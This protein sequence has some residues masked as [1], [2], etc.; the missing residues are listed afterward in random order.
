MAAQEEPPA[1]NSPVAGPGADQ[2]SVQ[3]LVGWRALVRDLAQM[4]RFMSRLPVPRLPFE[5]DAH[6]LPDFAT[7]PRMLPLAGLVV[8]LPALIVIA[9]AAGLRL[10]NEIVALLAIGAL[11]FTTGA[12]HED[13]LADTFDG[14]AGG[15]TVEK[16]LEIMKDSRIGSFGALALVLALLLRVACLAALLDRGGVVVALMAFL[17]AA[18]LSRTASLVPMTLLPPARTGGFSAAV[19]QP[20]Q[21][22]LVLALVVALAIVG[23]ASEVA[24]WSLLGTGLACLLALLATGLISF[25][26]LRS[27]GG[28]TGD[29]AGAAQQLA[30]IA[31]LM[32]LLISSVATN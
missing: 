18:V 7:A 26:A 20:T 9:L 11:A 25:W 17:G 3:A 22:T 13:G 24:G 12:M 31:F 15:R 6:A 16:R 4:I 2:T 8:A 27:I 29:I 23:A 14:L 19:G 1:A 10:P 28:Q 32:G 5:Q 30:E 21:Q